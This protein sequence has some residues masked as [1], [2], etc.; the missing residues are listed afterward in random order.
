MILALAFAAFAG[1]AEYERLFGPEPAPVAAA[2]AEASPTPEAAGPDTDPAPPPAVVATSAPVTAAPYHP[3]E[4]PGWAFSVG[5]LLMGGGAM[6]WLKQRAAAP[7]TPPL[8]VLHRQA[9]GDRSSLVLV[10]VAT[11]D[12]ERRR[13]LIGTG[14]GA[15]TLVSDLGGGFD[16]VEPAALRA[17]QGANEPVAPRPAPTL[18]APGTPA[19]QGSSAG[20]SA[21]PPRAANPRFTVTAGPNAANIADEILAE[22][23]TRGRWL[24]VAGDDE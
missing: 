12:G 6:W 15:P 5:A 1:D 20:P 24:A 11:P 8:S 7:T 16:D 19:P 23:R 13:L 18:P 22:R 21:P 10:E 2:P 14:G 4:I 3:P 9:I 17:A